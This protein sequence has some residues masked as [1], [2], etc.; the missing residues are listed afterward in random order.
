MKTDGTRVF[1]AADLPHSSDSNVR[2]VALKRSRTR[3]PYKRSLGRT[4][5]IKLETSKFQPNRFW[6]IFLSPGFRRTTRACIGTVRVSP[7][8][9]GIGTRNR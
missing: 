5:C 3:M 7:V 8:G 1:D 9:V 2:R 4:F 6:H